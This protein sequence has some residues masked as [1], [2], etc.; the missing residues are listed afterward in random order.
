M[1]TANAGTRLPAERA[2]YQMLIDGR[3]VDALSGRTLETVSPLT[4][5]AWAEVPYADSA[6]VDLAVRAARAAFEGPWA[7][8]TASARGRLLYRLAE[9]LREQADDLARTESIDNG[10]LLR[11]MSAQLTSLPGWYEYFGGLADKIEGSTPPPTK[12]NLFNY[13]RHEAIGVVGIVLPWNSPLLLLTFKLAPALAAGCTVVIKPAEYT[14]VSAIKFASLFERAGFPPGVVNVV[15]GGRDT[16]AALVAHP[17]VDKIAFTGSTDSGIAVMK[18]AAEHLAPVT[19]ELGGK[20]PNIVFGDADLG[21]A[22]NGVISGIFAATGQTCVA[23]SRLLVAR[24]VHDDLVKR[25]V[26]RATTIRLGDP[27][28]ADTE[29]GPC[30]NEDQLFKVVDRVE[31]AKKD[32]ATVLC[33]GR[34]PTRDDLH[35]GYFYEPTV[36]GDVTNDM[37]IAQEEIFGPVLC[38]IPFESESEAVA[39]AN[40]TRYGLG[41][42]VWTT[43]MSRAH[44]VAHQIRAGNVWINCYRMFTYNMPFGGFKSSG[45]GREN[46]VDALRSYME[47]KSVWINL[48]EDTR[49]PFV[50][51]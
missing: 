27:L 3:L 43:N 8:L 48:S 32:G 39:I 18:S 42:G 40:D 26:E 20:S 13:T 50:M 21:A 16:G 17:G 51:G 1:D 11:E 30:A 22:A 38:V 33:G 15:T 35:G 4:G 37:D 29:M 41:A 34:R 14:P 12:E 28:L 23:G 9:G 6:D 36:L 45:I 49:D 5:R 31:R 24:D 44:R 47:T 19:L 25:V 46:G 2:Q 10:K 7:Q